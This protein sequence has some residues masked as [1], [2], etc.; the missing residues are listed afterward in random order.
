MPFR[1]YVLVVVAAGNEGAEES[2][3]GDL[4]FN[5]IG[6]PATAKN[7]LTL[8]ASATDRTGSDFQQTWAQ[9]RPGTFTHPR[10]I[11]TLVA[12][13]PDVPAV[14]SSRGPTD[15]D[16]IKPDVRALGTFILSTRSSQAPAQSLEFWTDYTTKRYVYIGGT[17]MAAPI[18]AGCAAVVRQY[19][20]EEC[21]CVNPSAA[22]LKAVLMA[23]VKRLPAVKPPDLAEVVGYPDVDQGF[24]RIDLTNVLPHPAAPGGRRLSFVDVPNHSAD[25]LESRAPIG[26]ARKAVRTYTVQLAAGATDPL[27]VVLA[28][29]PTPGASASRTTC[30]SKCE[31]PRV[32][33]SAIQITGTAGTPTSTTE[34]RMGCHS[35]SATTWGTFGSRE[36]SCK[37]GNTGSVS[38]RK[39]RRALPRGSPC[40]CA[41]S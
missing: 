14:S 29:T 36:R 38:L 18:V 4:R 19:L 20:R 30:K 13:D 6:A 21:E 7:V 2:T 39:T 9:F 27:R 40:V 22:L 41:A 24:G 1:C 8:G 10:A 12:G 28:W 3:T 16:S 15:F 17:S 31:G 34:A 35:T 11:T 25:A 23:S 5:T 33:S 32:T 26:A 37:K